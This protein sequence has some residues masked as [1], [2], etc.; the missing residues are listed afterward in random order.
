MISTILAII[1]RLLVAGILWVLFF[2]FA[3]ALDLTWHVK[4]YPLMSFVGIGL[5]AWVLSKSLSE[6]DAKKREP[7]Y[8]EKRFGPSRERKSEAN[9]ESRNQDQ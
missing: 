5:I 1:A 3:I 9:A 2:V 8:Y 4:L 6:H 7:E